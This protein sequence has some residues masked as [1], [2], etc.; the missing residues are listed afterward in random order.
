VLQRRAIRDEARR[1]GLSTASNVGKPLDSHRFTI[2]KASGEYQ[3][4]A[5]FSN[6]VPKRRQKHA[7]TL[8]QSRDAVL[9]DTEL[10][11]Q[12]LL[13]QMTSLTKIAQR[14]FLRNQFGCSG[15][16]ARALTPS[17]TEV[18]YVTRIPTL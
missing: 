11:R 13:C 17:Q 3:L 6:V 12:A 9:F 14:F 2:R 8:L 18:V 7:T 16:D 15:F 1:A 4:A 5:H 10:F